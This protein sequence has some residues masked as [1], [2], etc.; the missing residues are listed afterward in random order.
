LL[1]WQDCPPPGGGPFKE[2]V[3]VNAVCTPVPSPAFGQL[4]QQNFVSILPGI[5][6][7]TRGFFRPSRCGDAFQERLA[8]VVGLAWK[9]FAHLAERGIDASCFPVALANF[10]CRAVYGGRRVGGQEAAT[11]VLSATA[12]RRHGFRVGRLPACG[13][14]AGTP[15]E[16]ALRDNSQSE[17]PAQVAFRVDFAA[18]LAQLGER[19]RRLA[20]D[21][22]LGERTKHLAGKYGVSA[23]R[24]AQKRRALEH[25]WLCFNGELPRP[26]ER[27]LA[28]TV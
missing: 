17:V 10:A 15:L 23:A 13:S 28:S 11:D 2:A 24:I 6:R 1:P 12:Q 27:P 8:D 18:W 7:Y 22:A 16:E 20:L 5:E 26:V 4:V 14:L 19:D 25:D 21:M 9:W 3:L